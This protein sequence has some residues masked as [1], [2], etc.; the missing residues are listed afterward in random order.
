L[1]KVNEAGG[2][3]YFNKELHQQILWW[4]QLPD[5]LQLAA[6]VAAALDKKK[7]APRPTI[8]TIEQRIQDACEQAE[9]A[10]FR[11]GKKK[12]AAAKPAKREKGALAKP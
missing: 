9:E 3:L 4:T 5:L 7:P 6:P 8:Q 12:E 1:L 2:E 10:G 11:I